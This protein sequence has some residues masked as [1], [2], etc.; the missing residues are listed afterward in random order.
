MA[1]LVALYATVGYTS[2]AATDEMLT[3][4]P[5]RCAR[6][7]GSACLH[8]ITQPRRLMAQMRSNASSVISSGEASPPARLTPTL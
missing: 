4:A 5:A 3:I 1:A 8:A 2:H 6:M 7:I